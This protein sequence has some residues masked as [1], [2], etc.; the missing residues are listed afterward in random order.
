MPAC[1]AMALMTSP[2][3][4]MRILLL[5]AKTL[6][7]SRLFDNLW[8]GTRFVNGA[9]TR[10]VLTPRTAKM[11]Q[12]FE[13]SAHHGT[14]LGVAPGEGSDAERRA[15]EGVDLLG[16]NERGA[17]LGARPA[18]EIE[19]ALQL[20]D[21]LGPGDGVLRQPERADD[22]GVAGKLGVARVGRL[23]IRIVLV[24]RQSARFGGHPEA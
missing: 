2:L 10:A 5:R 20:L 11:A 18:H 7:F 19:C 8:D 14:D 22:P 15:G 4:A 1:S 12:R 17:G 21:G 13:V 9:G 6:L 16:Q 3:P 24:A 23:L